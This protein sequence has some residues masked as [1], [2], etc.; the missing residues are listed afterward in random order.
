MGIFLV[1]ILDG[2]FEGIRDD[3]FDLVQLV[4]ST[5]FQ[6]VHSLYQALNIAIDIKILEI[7]ISQG[8]GMRKSD[9]EVDEEVG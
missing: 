2:E 5:L 1:E 4:L 3:P 7:L 6:E 9:E 8:I